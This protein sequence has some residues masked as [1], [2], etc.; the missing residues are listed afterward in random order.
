MSDFEKIWLIDTGEAARV[1]CDSPDPSN[2][3]DPEDVAGP[4]ILNADQRIAELETRLQVFADSNALLNEEIE[5]LRPDAE[6]WRI[7]SSPRFNTP[8]AV[9]DKDLNVL[10]GE[11]A[12]KAADAAMKT[13]NN[14]ENK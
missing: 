3:I 5:R 8:L 12:D 13:D 14:G 11:E 4:Y 1:W 9:V 10:W 6:R 2:G 7:T